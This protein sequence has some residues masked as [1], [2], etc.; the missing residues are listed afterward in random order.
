MKPLSKAARA[1]RKFDYAMKKAIRL[2]G[3]LNGKDLKDVAITWEDNLPRDDKEMADIM[4][5]RT[6]NKATISQLSAIKKMDDMDNTAAE[7]ELAQIL[8]DENMANP[9]TMPNIGGNDMPPKTPQEMMGGK[10]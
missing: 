6:G 1:R 3:Q 10:L 8:D 2:C 5:V 7:E 4:A 9:L